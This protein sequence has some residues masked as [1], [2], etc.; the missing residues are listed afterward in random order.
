MNFSRFEPTKTLRN[1]RADIDTLFDRFVEKPL[2]IITGQV[3]PPL[4]IVETD[5]EL[6][7]RMD[8]PGVDE[9]DIEV[10]IQNESL[11]IRGQKKEERNEPGR[12]Y[13]VVERPAG[14]FSR[15]VRLPVQVRLDMVRATFK[16]GVLEVELPKKE[17]AQARKIEIKAEG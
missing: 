5:T 13:H 8:L 11:T 12:T 3:V 16:K 1:L 9:K 2:G 14:P 7:V 10:S 15:T 4:D 6:L 17:L